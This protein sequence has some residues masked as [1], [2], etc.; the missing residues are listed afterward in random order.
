MSTSNPL[1]PT[2]PS[3]DDP[4]YHTIRY[5]SSSGSQP[6]HASYPTESG[7]RMSTSGRHP[8]SQPKPLPLHD[9]HR[10]GAAQTPQPS[11]SHRPDQNPP[12]PQGLPNPH[13]NRDRDPNPDSDRTIPSSISTQPI[14]ELSLARRLFAHLVTK[15]T[16]SRTWESRTYAEDTRSSNTLTR[17]VEHSEPSA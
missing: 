14:E 15:P 10:P 1:V 11:L 9:P 17:D 13:S 3:R 6:A 7:T 16:L 4:S 2:P 12:M 8:P 5:H